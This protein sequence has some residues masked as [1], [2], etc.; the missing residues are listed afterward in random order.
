MK[1]LA[2]VKEKEVKV[3]EEDAIGDGEI[4]DETIE[5]IEPNL[6]I[7][8][9]L[10][11]PKTTKNEW[12]QHSLFRTIYNAGGKFCSIIVDS[13]SMK[14]SLKRWLTSFS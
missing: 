13:G 8:L 14:N 4:L 11:A 7:N 1:K 10:V 2:R 5:V 3:Q 12:R 9:V 6:V